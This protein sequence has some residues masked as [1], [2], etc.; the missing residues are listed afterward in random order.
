MNL[1]STIM[2]N[3]KLKVLKILEIFL[4]IDTDE[5]VVNGNKHSTAIVARNVA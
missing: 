4:D 5:N 3:L 2:V 1:Y